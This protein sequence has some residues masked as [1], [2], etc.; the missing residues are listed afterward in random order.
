MA[1]LLDSFQLLLVEDNRGD[2]ILVRSYLDDTSLKATVHAANTLQQ[3]VELLCKQ[4]FEVVILDLGLPDSQGLATLTELCKHCPD[5]AVIVL[6][7]M[8]DSELANEAMSA[9]AQDFLIKG[10]IHSHVLNRCINYAFNRKRAEGKLIEAQTRLQNLADSASDAIVTVD[11]NFKILFANPSAESLFQCNE[12]CLHGESLVGKFDSASQSNFEQAV[13]K[14]TQ[15]KEPV[16][17]NEIIIEG[18]ILLENGGLA[19]VEYTLGRWIS[20]D[21]IYISV[22]F[23]DITQR[24]KDAEEI[25]HA[26]DFQRAIAAIMGLYGK[27]DGLKKK[28]KQAVEEVAN[29]EW[30]F[31]D[32]KRGI[33]VVVLDTKTERVIVTSKLVIEN[34]EIEALKQP[35]QH[36]HNLSYCVTPQ[37]HLWVSIPSSRNDNFEGFLVLHSREGDID[38]QEYRYQIDLLLKSFTSIIQDHYTD[39]TLHTM[40]EA[41]AQS[42]TG[43]VM[44]DKNAIIYFANKAVTDITGYSLDEVIGQNPRIFNSGM[45][46]K[47]FYEDLWSK[48]KD[49]KVWR[50]ELQNRRKDGQIYWEYMVIAPVNTSIG[51][52]SFIALKENIDQR[53]LAE[54]QLIHMATHDP[55]TQLPNRVLLLDTMDQALID[56]KRKNTGVTVMLLDLD[57][58]KLVND[59]KG[60][61]AGDELLSLIANR[62][63]VHLH[64]TNIVGRQGGDEFIAI[65]P[66]IYDETTV[67]EIVNKVC[68][69]VSHPYLLGDFTAQITCS[70]GMAVSIGGED[71][72][73]ELYRKADIAMYKAKSLGGSRG[74]FF[75]EELDAHLNSKIWYRKAIIEALEAQQ[76]ELHYQP[77]IDVRTGYLSGVEALIRWYHPEKGLI[78]P[79]EFIPIAEETGDIIQI[80]LWVVREACKQIRCWLDDGFH[81]PRVAIN[82]ASQQLS[83]PQLLSQVHSSL[84]HYNLT[85]DMLEIELT[86]SEMMQS[87]EESI[88][89][90]QQFHKMGIHISGDDFGTGYCSL[91]YLKRLPL[92]RLKI[93]RSFIID[94]TRDQESQAIASMIITLG[95]S[96][97]LK[98]LAEG[99]EEY[100]QLALLRRLECDEFQ[101]FYCSPAVRANDFSE[102][103]LDK[104]KLVDI[105]EDVVGNRYLLILDDELAVLSALTRLLRKEGYELLCTTDPDEALQFLAA[106]EVGVILC[107][108]LMPKITG[109]EFLAQIKDMY[110]DTVRMILS[111][112]TD[113]D[114]IISAINKGFV[115]RFLTK[116]WDDEMLRQHI[117]EAFLFYLAKKNNSVELN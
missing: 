25:R 4:P 109:T 95:R 35:L 12:S 117:E 111:G 103:Y 56:A 50:G 76:F 28:L 68:T 63:T 24:K 83:D 96:L 69:E 100:E 20:K 113:L 114:T 11:Q 89:I 27:H 65:L 18:T 44:A 78:S 97:G 49:G 1:P 13:S 90:L 82:I 106:H 67:N 45:Q 94:I 47:A 52:H 48:V 80:G 87:P 33:G 62:L 101:G 40:M 58:F 85:P 93:D 10:K 66:D 116:P 112:Y 92:H 105:Q 32:K 104:G 60:H 21:S 3:A 59:Q 6:T 8:N 54:Q 110:P 102:K 84:E 16:S 36:T 7:G 46:N 19:F 38:N 71:S 73:G 22:F 74:C 23:R 30:L 14:Y 55:L 86:E 57:Q 61:L 41:I 107:D 53:K 70:V 2:A 5:A 31:N 26:L 108:Q 79:V 115:Y 98:V 91:S 81:P 42:P 64:G 43:V 72:S 9:G 75:T 17:P 39:L 51:D 15:N 99:V 37:N 88:S 29:I 77:Q 34:S